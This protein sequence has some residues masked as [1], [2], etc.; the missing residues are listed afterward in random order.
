MRIRLIIGAVLLALTGLIPQ[1]DAAAR[2]RYATIPIV[3]PVQPADADF[4]TFRQ[5]LAEA[6]ARKDAAAVNALVTAQGFFWEREVGTLPPAADTPGASLLQEALALN[7]QASHGW[8]ALARF[9]A[10]PA[11]ATA[12]GRAGVVCTPAYPVFNEP[13]LRAAMIATGSDVYDWAYPATDTVPVLSRPHADAK[14]VATPGAALVHVL[15]WDRHGFAEVALPDGRPGYVATAQV[16]AL[17]SDQLCY[18]KTDAGWRI[19]GYIGGGE[20]P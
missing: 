5:T 12:P 6:A 8:A 20:T 15:A 18:I 10:D 7:D 16:T 2:A 9:A 3:R 17:I 1:A 14:P 4:A 13:A 11:P 19:G